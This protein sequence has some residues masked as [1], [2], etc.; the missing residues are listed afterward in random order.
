[1]QN[2]A[3][4]DQMKSHS[5]RSLRVLNRTLG[6]LIGLIDLAPMSYISPTTGRQYI[7]LEAGGAS[8]AP[9]TADYI[10]AFALP[11]KPASVH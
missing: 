4:T 7:V 3:V 5:L 9:D 10:M 6:G 11:A 1:M 2:R 8:H